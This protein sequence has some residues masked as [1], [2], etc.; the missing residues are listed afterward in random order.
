[1]KMEELQEA[2][3][4]SNTKDSSEKSNLVMSLSKTW[5]TCE[6]MDLSPSCKISGRSGTMQNGT[7]FQLETSVLAISEK[8]SGLLPTPTLSDAQQRLN[9]TSQLKRKSPDLVVEIQLRALKNEGIISLPTPTARD[10]KDQMSPAAAAAQIEK[11]NSPT[12]G[13]LAS[14]GRLNLPTPTTFDSG[15]PMPPRKKNPSG[16]QKPPLVSVIGGKLNPNFV[17][18]LMMYPPSYTM[19]LE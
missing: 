1:M 19:P 9:L 3:F 6:V 15:N 5:Q 7:L 17:E 13:L 10:W 2:D 18:W 14:A 11:R 8:E 16:G 4:G 12:L